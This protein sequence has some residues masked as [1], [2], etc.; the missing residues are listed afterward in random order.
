MQASEA[1]RI[2]QALADGAAGGADPSADRLV[3]VGE[4]PHA[5]TLSAAKGLGSSLA[6]CGDSFRQ[7][8]DRPTDSE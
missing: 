1:L 7:M 2:I 4:G 5:V 8:T 3:D 6:Q